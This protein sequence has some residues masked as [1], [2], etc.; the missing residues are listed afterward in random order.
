MA[1]N[2]DK[3]MR[4]AER[5]VKKGRY[6]AAIKEYERL[7]DAT[8]NDPGLINKVGD[9]YGRLGK[10]DKAVELYERIANRFE[11]QGFTNKAIAI[12]K[13]I[14]RIAP[15]RLDVFEKLAELYLAQG[16]VSEATNQL[17][18]VADW[19]QKQGDLD[20]A[21]RVLER[22]VQIDPGNHV[23]SLRLADLLMKRG[24]HERAGEVYE[25]LG[26][27]LLGRGRL[28]EAERLYRHVLEA[29]PPD[30]RIFLP[31]CRAALEA[32]RLP[33]ALE[34]VREA[35]RRSP[36]DPDVAA[37]HLRILVASGD[38]KGAVATAEDLLARYPDHGE[39]RRAVG[40]ALLDVGEGGRAK[41]LLLPVL[42]EEIAAA[43]TD[44][45]QALAN[46]L[47]RA[48]PRDPDVLQA[49]IS[50]FEP[51][52][53][54]ETLIT[55]RAA[56]ADTYL[57]T[58]RK[59][60]A[61]ALYQGLVLEDPENDLFRRRLEE[62]TGEVPEI[63]E[64]PVPA[65]PQ[66]PEP[67]TGPGPVPGPEPE[68]PFDPKE[69]LAEANVFAKYGLVDK[70]VEHL[71][72][73]LSA[74]PQMDE[75]RERLATLLAER[76]ELERAREVAAPL[77]ERYRAAGETEK[78]EKLAALV[79][80]G[81]PAGPAGVSGEVPAP[82][83]PPA[84]PAVPVSEDEE[85]DIL[86]LDLDEVTA[87]PVPEERPAVAPEGGIEFELEVEAPAE[88]AAPEAPAGAQPAP[89]EE[90]V[91]ITATVTGPPM[92][93]LEQ[94]DFFIEQRLYDDALRMLS[95]LEERYPDDPE[96]LERRARLKAA[97]VL[98]DEVT[99]APEEAAADLFAG[100]E[101]YID[102]AKELEE[103]LAEEERMVQEA[104]GTG[105][106]E[107]LLEEVFREFQ[108]GVAEQLSEED[109]DT[110]FNLGIAYKEMGLL[111]EAIG[112]FQIAAR[113]PRY[114][115]ESYCMIGLCHTEQG[116]YPE[117]A[118]WYRKALALPDLPREAR[119]GVLYDLARVLE[120]AGEYEEAA[121]AFEAI[122][123]EDPGYRDVT[124]RL[125]GL[126]QRRQ[127]N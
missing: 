24:D 61:Q 43:R 30:G 84:R 83:P 112:E 76:G 44:A 39:V 94:I 118:E 29:D 27:M 109:S 73:I 117:A 37:M 70:A 91:E 50:A 4:E 56:L 67:E 25:R 35:Q 97:G 57:R 74:F 77:L 120:A 96:L 127:A 48:L 38:A 60:E 55:L 89:D 36:E 64:V 63:V 110:H 12:Y 122:A 92:A 69:R 20:N 113:D 14:N 88:G 80:E 103:E 46:R 114:R 51:S 71:H 111:A 22:L 5:L 1:A 52:G 23:A 105:Q 7:L 86:V 32:G 107:A 28:D 21:I 104:T 81:G 85:E 75:A 11:E 90:L 95:D 119:H 26:E 47:L 68:P 6:D 123:A 42:R 15:E 58:G 3:I 82:E 33:V 124:A 10:I 8:P 31:F 79:G 100:E 98:L 34:F 93:E 121:Q 102:L 9:L 115:L 126:G 53:D 13:K 87:E 78:L 108:K 49:A 116:Q 18:A 16:I 45:A 66:P 99:E 101:E 54:R 40:E 19:Y 62:L 125:Q 59:A 65:P 2:R 41:E 17:K 106:Q 72:E